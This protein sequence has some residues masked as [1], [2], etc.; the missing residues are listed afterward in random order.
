MNDTHK[1]LL[2]FIEASGFDVEEEKYQILNDGTRYEGHDI[3]WCKNALEPEIYTDYK[4]TK[5]KPNT[6]HVTTK[7]GYVLVDGVVVYNLIDGETVPRL[8]KP[9]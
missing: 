8:Q 6:F 3:T 5:K 7:N 1:L 4:V 9:D 2:A